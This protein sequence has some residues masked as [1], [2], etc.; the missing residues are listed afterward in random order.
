MSSSSALRV[1]EFYSGIGGFH[2]A[3][4]TA[5]L[6]H[7]NRD[8]MSYI[9]PPLVLPYDNNQN[10]NAT[11]PLNFPHTTV[12][13]TNIEHITAVELD[14][15]GCR[16]LWLMSPPCQPY[17]RGGARR[18]HEDPRACSFAHLIR[19]VLPSMSHRPSAIVIENVI[20]FHESESFALLMRTLPPLGYH[21]VVHHDITPKRCGLPNARHRVFVTASL[22]LPL[23]LSGPPIPQRNAEVVT[24]GVCLAGVVIPT[25]A[26]HTPSAAMF[27][28][29]I[30]TTYKFSISTV[31]STNTDCFTK[32][33]AEGVKC[34]MK[35]VRGSGSMFLS[36]ATTAE[37]GAILSRKE[38]VDF[39]EKEKV[40][41]VPGAVIADPLCCTLFS[42]GRLRYF[43]SSEL[44][45]LFGFPDS[46]VFPL[47]LEEHTKIKL[48]GNSLCVGNAAEIIRT[49]LT[50]C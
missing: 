26:F 32:G 39:C 45:R 48:I 3:L 11:Y 23:P 36:D 33:Y 6:Y 31:E 19:N 24:V 13:T 34:P 9:S 22:A 10:A 17:T 50:A 46:F 1:L 40:W 29:P 21:V 43:H 49:V 18:M 41:R 15:I 35:F 37:M 4:H 8:Q 12:C 28:L 27:S 14:A 16:D 5:L 30:F 42:P 25:S 2:F 38:G 20:G 47:G 44:L 7:P